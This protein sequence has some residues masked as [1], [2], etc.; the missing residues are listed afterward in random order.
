[1]THPLGHSGGS[2]GKYQEDRQQDAHGNDPYY[3]EEI[4]HV[5]KNIES[6]Y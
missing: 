6:E 4:L 3:E 1:M 2:R 5:Q